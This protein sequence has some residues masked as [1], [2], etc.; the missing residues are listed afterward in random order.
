MPLNIHSFNAFRYWHLY[1][2]ADAEIKSPCSSDKKQHPVSHSRPFRLCI[3]SRSS[4][5][6]MRGSSMEPNAISELY[7]DL[8]TSIKPNQKPK[9]LQVASEME[10]EQKQSL[11]FATCPLQIQCSCYWQTPHPHHHAHIFLATNFS[12][13]RLIKETQEGIRACPQLFPLSVYLS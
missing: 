9:T 4:P 10:K 12:P 2:Q 11:L 7:W 6:V 5:E 8:S 3:S 13:N 1:S